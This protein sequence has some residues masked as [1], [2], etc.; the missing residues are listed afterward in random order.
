MKYVACNSL[1]YWNSRLCCNSGMQ[2]VNV[3]ANVYCFRLMPI[4]K[5]STL[6]HGPSMGPRRFLHVSLLHA[7]KLCLVFRLRFV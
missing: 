6:W 1:K 5:S 2:F 4:S 7:S 3:C